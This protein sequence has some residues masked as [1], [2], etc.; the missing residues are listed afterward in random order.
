VAAISHFCLLIL[1]NHV[2]MGCVSSTGIPELPADLAV[3][4]GVSVEEVRRAKSA[5]EAEWGALLQPFLDKMDIMIGLVLI[6]VKQPP[7]LFVGALDRARAA[8]TCCR[9]C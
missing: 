5:V 6:Y 7:Q 1:M 3:A 2:Q 9:V 8:S 4:W